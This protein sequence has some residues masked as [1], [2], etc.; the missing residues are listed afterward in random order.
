MAAKGDSRPADEGDAVSDGEG[1]GGS[2]V[3]SGCDD[4][5]VG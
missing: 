1:E 4:V 3:V 2:R 5:A